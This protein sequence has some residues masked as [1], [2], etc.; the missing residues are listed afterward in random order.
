[1]NTTGYWVGG[2]LA[3]LGE[4]AS[5]AALAF[6]GASVPT[7]TAWRVVAAAGLPLVAAVLWGLFA[8]PRAKFRVPV[9]AVVTK[10]V[11]QGG[12]VAALVATGH[13]VPGAILAAAVVLG[14]LLTAR[15]PQEAR[16]AAR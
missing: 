12:A 3:F 8:A 7:G 5:L 16:P 2:L 9:L 10:I 1:M 14:A 15:A 6:W 13:P 4:L 11:V